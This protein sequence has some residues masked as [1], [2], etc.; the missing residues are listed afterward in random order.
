MNPGD[1]KAPSPIIAMFQALQAM[2]PHWYVEI[3]QP[4]GTGWI[5]GTALVTAREG[6][7][8]ALLGCIGEGLH[9]ADRRTIAASFALRYG[10][11]SGVAMAPY[12][13]YH[14]VP[15]IT[16]DNVSFKFNDNT[17]FERAA[18]HQP[19]GVM[20]PQEG[21]VPHPSVQWLPS[22]QALLD[23]LRASLVQQA[24]PIV[25]ALYEWS[26]FS[27]KGIWGMIASAW[28]SQFINIVGEIGEQRN[29]LPAVR[30]FFAGND[31]VSQM[32]PNFFPVTYKQMTHV[33]HRGASCCRFYLLRPGQYC[34]SCPLISQEERLQRHQAWMKHL[35]ET[36]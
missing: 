29:A 14:C 12:L 6:P 26:H 22:P 34:A 2:R 25:D 5:P 3:G 17:S 31:V 24:E 19:E 4:R 16:L 9:T 8:Q 35:I 20:L 36:S 21:M 30:Q 15:N 23:W 27:V 1:G 18:L 7:F 28:G 13:L 32:Q 10:W 11:S 33:Y